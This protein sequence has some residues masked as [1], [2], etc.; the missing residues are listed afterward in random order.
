MKKI[1]LL[2]IALMAMVV[3]EAK[4]IKITLTDGTTKVYTSSELSAIDFNDDGTL[5]ITTYD[6][7]QLPALDADFSTLELGDEAVITDIFPDTLRFDIDAGDVSFDLQ[8]ERPIIKVNY[9]YP[10]Q[11]PWGEPITLSGTMLIPEEIWNGTANSEGILMVHHY[12]KFNRD[13]APTIENGAIENM[14]LSNPL[15][16]NYIIVESDFYGFGATVRFP[17]AFLQGLVNARSSLDGLLAARDLLNEQSI[18]YGPLCFNIGYS[19]A[20]YDALAAQKLR[21]LEYADRISF[22]KTFSGGGPSDVCEAYRLY[23]EID[24]TAYN[25]VPLLL[26]VCTKEIQKLDDIDYADVF[27]PYISGRIDELILSKAYSSWPVCDSI[28]REK[29]VHEILSETFCDLQSEESMRIQDILRGF[30]LTR[31]DWTPDPTQRIYLFHSRGDDYVP[32]QCARPM[33]PFLKSKGFEPSIIPGK[34]NLQT[35]FVVTNMGH[36]KATLVYFVQTLAAIEAWPQMYRDGQLKPIY[37]AVLDRID[38]NDPVTVLRYLDTCGFDCR[39]IIN[40]LLAYMSEASGS[41]GTGNIDLIALTIKLNEA[42]VKAGL[43]FQDLTEMTYDSG[44]DIMQLFTSLIAYLSETPDTEDV[45]TEDSETEN[46][47]AARLLR[48]VRTS[49]Q[50]PSDTYEQQ[51]RQWLRDGG[52]EF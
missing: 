2:F 19:S 35:N 7:Q 14:L 22:D 21:D 31:D 15:K 17:Q 42:L 4:V 20:G 43:T 23:V 52:V 41:E 24:S 12:T 44:I 11:D 13:E 5:T 30:N 26:M 37:Q 45:V 8:S 50:V 51:L 48:L 25:A 29:K 40:G 32:V 38:V 16:P 47:Q 1:V 39:A 3:S 6:G 18:G 27:Q 33:I 49:A 9:V 10:S 46:V 28:G 34:T 36:L